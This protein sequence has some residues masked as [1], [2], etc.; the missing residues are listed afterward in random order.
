[1][2]DLEGEGL[3][4]LLEKGHGAALGLI[5]L[6]REVDEARG[7]VDGHIEVPLAALAVSGAQL[8]Q[9]LHVHMDKAEIVVLEA[10]MRSAGADSPRQAGPALRL[11]GAGDR[12]AGEGR[13]EE[14]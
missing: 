7:A 9:V 12:G 1:M 14:G 5:I 2:G 10:A 4:R 11:Q 8:G 3:D 6:D 13:E